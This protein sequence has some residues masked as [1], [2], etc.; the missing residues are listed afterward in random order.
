[1]QSM[2]FIMLSIHPLTQGLRHTSLTGP[3]PRSPTA[4]INPMGKWELP[5]SALISGELH[6]PFKP[7]DSSVQK[8]SLPGSVP[9]EFHFLTL[10]DVFVE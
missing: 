8:Q 10:I 1:M 9:F 4:V 5:A 2:S 3:G 7:K 6:V